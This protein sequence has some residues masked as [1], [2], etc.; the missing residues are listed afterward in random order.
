ML[1]TIPERLTKSNKDGSARVLAI[2]NQKAA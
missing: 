2:A 1:A